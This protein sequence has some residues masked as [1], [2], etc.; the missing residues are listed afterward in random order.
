MRFTRVG[1]ALGVAA[2]VAVFAGCSSNGSSSLGPIA[3][4]IG[5]TQSIVRNH[6]LMVLPKAV[7]NSVHLGNYAT[8][9]VSHQY[10]KPDVTGT[11]LTGCQF[12]GVNCNLYHLPSKTV[13]GTIAASY[14]NGICVDKLSNVWIPDGGATTISEYPKGSVS[15]IK[16]LS[17]DGS[18]PSVCAVDSNGT[19]YVG[20]IAADVIQV[21]AGGST[22][23]TRFLKVKSLFVGTSPAG[24]IIGLAVNETPVLH[25][26]AV[27]WI[28]F[29]TGLSGVDEYASAK[30]KNETTISTPSVGS[31][32]FLGGVVFDN[33]ENLVENDQSTGSYYV[34]PTTGG[35]ACNTVPYVSSDAVFTALNKPNTLA[36]EGDATN[37]DI[38]EITYGGCTGGGVF[39]KTF[40]GFAASSFVIGVATS[41]G[42]TN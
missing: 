5:G 22:T 2:A 41:P 28:N 26:L 19:V 40:G 23:P 20:D 29:S 3:G 30:Q 12:F 11:Y 36:F 18:Q 9:G 32:D 25:T 13:V 38:A 10:V 37:S 35:A 27:S 1:Y 17:G 42:D 15:A 6:P 14:V 31:S 8:T 24:Y 34:E 33:A 7:I 21:Y 16:T 39:K 4:P